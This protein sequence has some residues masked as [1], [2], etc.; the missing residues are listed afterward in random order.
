MVLGGQP[1]G[2]VGHRQRTFFY[3]HPRSH[4]V[5]KFDRAHKCLIITDLFRR[6]A[7]PGLGVLMGQYITLLRNNAN[8]RNL[9]LGTVVSF[10]GDWFNLIASAELVRTLTSSGLAVSTLFLLR[11]LPLFLFTPVAGVLADRF[12]RRNIMILTDLLRGVTVLSFLLIRSAD[13]LWLFYLL[14]FLQFTLSALFTP[15][16]SAVLANIVPKEDLITAN[17]LDAFTWSSMLALGAFAGGVVAGFFGTQAAFITDALTFALSAWFIARIIMPERDRARSYAGGGWLQFLDGLRYLRAEHF[18]LAVSLVKAGGSLAWGA[19]NV[20]E[21]TFASQIF[22][23][24]LAGLGRSLRLSS[25]GAATLGAIYFVTGLGT[26]I[27]PIVM[28]RWLGDRPRRLLL[29]ITIGFFLLAA[30]IFGL[31]RAPTLPT[32]LASSLVRTFGSGTIWVFSAA[33]L[34]MVVPD[35]VRGR[36]FA[37]EFA[38]L[39]LTQSI[40]IFAA[41]YF[42]DSVGM[43]VRQV[44]AISAATALAVAI[45]WLLFY[46]VNVVRTGWQAPRLKQEIEPGDPSD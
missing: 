40:S 10:L 34:Q 5:A 41:G 22:N 45:I 20:L 30:G 46:Y 43:D 2:R 44:T 26:G 32:F 16:K 36:V 38:M 1:P 39:T 14:T 8:Y 17:A 42:M 29:G 9:W 7:S 18:I 13:Q 33:M 25:P 3:C 12:D 24:E 28:R 19:I 27:G 4:N 37:F 6:H 21:V 11:F 35:R 15:A 31:S 23:D